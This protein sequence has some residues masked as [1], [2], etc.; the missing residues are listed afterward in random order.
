MDFVELERTF[1]EVLAPRDLNTYL[2]SPDRAERL[3][4]VGLPAGARLFSDYKLMGRPRRSMATELL[5]VRPRREL[6]ILLE[7]LRVAI[8]LTGSRRVA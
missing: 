8:E 2:G 6:P 5:C 3:A 7:A 1:A 4:Q